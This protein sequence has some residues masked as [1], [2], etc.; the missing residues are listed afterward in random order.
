MTQINLFRHSF[1]TTP[2]RIFA[3]SEALEAIRT[4]A[5]RRKIERLLAIHAQGDAEAY[6]TAKAQLPA[7]TFGGTFHPSRA[8]KH[9][10]QHSGIV[11]GDLDHLPNVEATR[12]TLCQDPH[13][14]YCF[15]SPSRAGLKLGVRITPVADDA[16]YKHAWA[17]VAAD[18]L[19]RYGV[20]WD[21]SGKDVSRLC[22]VSWDP[23]CYTNLQAEVSPVP[24]P[25]VTPPRPP[26]PR[27]FTR[28]AGDHRTRFAQRAM[29]LA[30]RMIEE[31]PEHHQHHARL[32]AARL[33][34]GYAARGLAE[35]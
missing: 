3:V 13:V 22:Y 1:D 6:R 11:H 28:A 20:T 18:Q 35:L 34:G 12:Q 14:V 2:L 16:A 27:P 30:V 7:F 5:C 17:V 26:V 33:L 9:L 31:A 19:A 25:L 32:R 15:L 23:D 24:P 29:E 10:A 8:I 4:G 21:P